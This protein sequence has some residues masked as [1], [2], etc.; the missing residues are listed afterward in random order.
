[1]LPRILWSPVV[2]MPVLVA[3]AFVHPIGALVTAIGLLA[4]WVG[5]RTES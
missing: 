4:L 2:F 1:M 3:F 5:L